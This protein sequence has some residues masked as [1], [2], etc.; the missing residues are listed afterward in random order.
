MLQQFEHTTVDLGSVVLRLNS[1]LVFSQQED[2][3]FYLIEHPIKSKFY[4]IGSAEYT[5]ISMLDGYTS[6]NQAISKSAALLGDQAINQHEASQICKWIVDQ[7]IGT[8]EASASAQRLSDSATK[9]RREELVA[10]T[11]PLTPKIDLFN[12]DRLMSLMNRFVGF[13]FSSLGAVVWL[14]LMAVGVW[15]LVTN[16]SEFFSQSSSLVSRDNWI[17]FAGIFI[18]LKL[19]HETG[20]GI[21]CKRF[22]G[23]V[24]RAGLVFILL[25]P[26]PYVDVTSSWRFDSKWNRA[27]V[28]FAG[29]Y[30]ELLIAA[31]AVMGWVFFQ[32][33][34][35]RMQ[36]FNIFV[37][38]S[39]MTLLFNANIL[40]RFD[41]YYI[42]SDLISVPNLASRGSQYLRYFGRK[43]GLGMK[44]A[45]FFWPEGKSKTI[46]IYAV[47]AL[48]W[49]VLICISL[50]IAAE[51]LLY[52][53][54]VVL[55]IVGVFLWV[56]IPIIK[57]LSFVFFNKRVTSA[58]RFRFVSLASI[59]AVV[60][61]CCWNYCPIYSS[62]SAPVIA[63]FSK[64][65]VVRTGV[66]GLL[67]EICVVDS[68]R[69]DKG[70]KIAVLE[71]RELELEMDRLK[72]E[73]ESNRQM[74]RIFRSKK[75]PAA[76][77]LQDE[78]LVELQKKLAELEQD[79]SEL[80]LRAPASG[81]VILDNL[82]SRIGNYIRS[83]DQV[84]SLGEGTNIVFHAMVSQTD[85]EN[86]R[87]ASAELLDVTLD[88][89]GTQ[90]IKSKIRNI[91]PRGQT[92][93]LHPSFGAM[94]GGPLLVRP[95]SASATE[96]IK[97]GL[98]VEEIANDWMLVNP[99]FHIQ[100]VSDSEFSVSETNSEA[101][102]L[103]AGQSGRVF[104]RT[105][106][107]T[108]GE[109][110]MDWYYRWLRPSSLR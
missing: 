37:S 62:L 66:G 101:N 14:F 95:V 60:A 100:L 55:A 8:T 92:D 81:K 48:F 28:G 56:V 96:D 42:F 47:A 34:F 44:E 80:V 50:V 33:P 29:M 51:K 43:Y 76:L 27:M 40:M 38:A 58:N 54:G 91:N 73:I 103:W 57:L 64:F 72:I 88:G 26:L 19:I 67:K 110:C 85:Y 45:P 108:L 102:T 1:E 12:P 106:Q 6:I 59:T 2:G 18:G 87:G 53:A 78:N 39:L 15:F 41:G 25:F 99:H 46:R 79:Q 77:D 70:Q 35:L 82:N 68:A 10:K 4:R 97:T 11:N 84:Y 7:E 31:V 65:R 75:E 52:G 49:R 90:A 24:P 3:K 22:G 93:L 104:L 5:F 63:D 17:W 74:A 9:A 105:Y 30:F 89:N 94:C 21:C 61:V 86:F 32:D 71:N 16:W 109:V 69:V 83:G 23:E 13:M 36:L 20:H 98:S 107:G